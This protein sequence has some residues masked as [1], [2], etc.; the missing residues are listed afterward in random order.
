MSAACAPRH[1]G[2]RLLFPEP[3]GLGGFT[4]I[5]RLLIPGPAGTLEALLDFNPKMTP[6]LGAVICHA[7][8][9]YS[10]TMHNKVVFRAARAAR[11]A[12]LPALRFNF[13]GVER[14]EGVHDKGMGECDDVRAA[15][16]FFGHRFPEL[17]VCVMGFSFGAWV[18]LRVG[19][20]DARAIA[21]VGLGLPTI[22][23]D[24]AYLRGVTKSK[25]IVQGTRDRYGRREDVQ[26]VFDSLAEPKHIHWVEDV[27][28]FFT[29]K[30]A[31]VQSVL[32]AFL[33]DTAE[34]IASIHD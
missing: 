3:R 7:H 10:G 8:P 9:L 6:R 23:S 15:L 26:A 1:G 19:A 24:F 12:G 34:R 33:R 17:P 4:K 29:G 16:D 13:R 32:H 14:S 31:E 25:L 28:H 21:L 27:D 5:E 2:P 20:E 18:G 30:L 11:E 22:D